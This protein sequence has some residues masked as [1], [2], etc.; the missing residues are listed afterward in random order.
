MRADLA[1]DAV[2]ERRDDFAA[3]GVVLGVGGEDQHHVER[4]PHRI[5]LNLHVAFLHDVE[6]AHLNLSGQVGQLV[7]GEDP[8]IGARQQAVMHVSS[9][10]MSCPRARGLDGVDVADHVRDG[11][12]RAWPAFPRSAVARQPGDGRRVAFARRYAPGMAGR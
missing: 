1:A 8:A 4:Q 11:H 3:R 7:D 6:Q 5:A 10:E 12:V 2:F 9:S